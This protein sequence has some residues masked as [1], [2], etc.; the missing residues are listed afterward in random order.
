M[1]VNTDSEQEE[2][3]LVVYKVWAIKGDV[4]FYTFNKQSFPSI[5]AAIVSYSDI[6]LYIIDGMMCQG[7]K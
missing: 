4:Q 1:F 6:V 2:L 3:V 7:L 5:L